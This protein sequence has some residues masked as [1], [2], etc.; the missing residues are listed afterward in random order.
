MT[1]KLSIALLLAMAAIAIAVPVLA[2][3][4]I[5]INVTESNGTNYDMLAMNMTLDVDYLASHQFIDEDG[6][7][8]RVK[9]SM[10]DNVPFMLVDDRLLFVSDI[11]AS[12]TTNFQL[13]TGNTALSNF[14]I[15][16]GHGGYVTITDTANLEPGGNF[17]LEWDG[18]VD[19]DTAGNLINKTDSI[20][21]ASDGAGHI[22]ATITKQADIDHT[23]NDGYMSLYAGSTTRAGERINSVLLG[24]IIQV[25]FK[26]SKTG[27]PTGTAYIRIR[28]VSDDS[29]IGTIGTIDVSTIAGT[30]TWY[31]FTGSVFNT[32]TQDLRFSFEYSGG[33]VDNYIRVL[34][35]SSN[36]LSSGVRTTY[37]GSWTD[38][39][40]D[41]A[42]KV[43][44]HAAPSVSAE[45]ETGGHTIIVNGDGLELTIYID[46]SEE[47]SDTIQ[48][49]V[50]TANNWVVGSDATP[51]F[52]Y[53]KHTVSSSLKLRYEP[54][55]IISGTTLLNEENP[56]TYD[57][58]FTFGSN[59]AGIAITHSTLQLEES[60]YP[61]GASTNPTDII[62]PEPAELISGVNLERL[63]HNPFSP[64]VEAIADSSDGKLTESLVWIGGAWF[65]LIGVV[66]YLFIK[67]REHL[68]FAALAGCGLSIA[69]YVMGIF[70]YWIIIVF[71][72]GAIA[73]IVH[74]KQPTW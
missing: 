55:D 23:D 6:L 20:V 50:N 18:Y 47:D 3:Y 21:V 30:A 69:F 26:M 42:I 13:T 63:S 37:S 8:V 60:Y 2:A 61:T 25:S 49:V 5:D 62:T 54:D 65:I 67:L 12:K 48:A 53:Y 4:Y 32:A 11:T 73:A 17:E 46:D 29:I 39:T 35:N 41:T 1:K 40:G 72:I 57:G 38:T 31:D 66:I 70:D 36:T 68:M 19:T 9:T 33:D 14:P 28:A 44:Y 15:I 51:Y 10:G 58:T 74:E 27:S 24:T 64:L 7:D 71:G 22:T 56:G 52:N 45:V 34:Y 16:A 59:P 43:H